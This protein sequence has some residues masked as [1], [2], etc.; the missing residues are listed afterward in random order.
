MLALFMASLGSQTDIRPK[1]SIKI[2]SQPCGMLIDTGSE[3]SAVSREWFLK[4][5]RRPKLTAATG[6]ITTAAG[7]NAETMGYWD[8]D[9]MCFGKSVPVRLF[10]FPKLSQ[11]GIL[12]MDVLSQD[13]L[14][15]N[16]NTQTLNLG[17]FDLKSKKQVKILEGQNALIPCESPPDFNGLLLMNNEINGQEEVYE[18]SKDKKLLV[19]VCNFSNEPIVIRRGQ[20]LGTGQSLSP[21]LILEKTDAGFVS[22]K[23]FSILAFST[24]HLKRIIM[25]R[26][27]LSVRKSYENLLADFADVFSKSET[28]LGKATIVKQRV[29]LKDPNKIT[30]IP[31]YRMAPHLKAVADEYIE[32]MLAAKIIRKSDSPF[33]SPLMLVRKA[34]KIDPNNPLKG[35]R[36]VL[37]YRK[38]NQNTVPDSYPMR[39]LQEMI[40]NPPRN[41]K[42]LCLVSKT[43]RLCH[44]R[45]T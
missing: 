15:F 8:T 34:T 35:Y 10:V 2:L 23:D 41:E 29:T 25:D 26:I 16:A 5:P 33:S 28:D 1:R 19:S 31:P 43:V 20:V 9:I 18:K 44:K 42:F 40:A 27:P 36:V 14:T 7:E 12:G 11:E 30:T 13:I 4:L 24:A 37:D 22:K 38:V 32:K 3:I 45:F 39:H 17:T 6:Q 21:E